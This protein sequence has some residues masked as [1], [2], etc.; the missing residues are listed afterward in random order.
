MA[1]RERKAMPAS[2]AIQ[3]RVERGEFDLDRPA[4]PEPGC[5]SWGGY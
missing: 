4:M 2:D 1:D 5:F 3:R